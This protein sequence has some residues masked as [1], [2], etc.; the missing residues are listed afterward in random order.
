MR[1]A[2]LIL[3]GRSRC[4]LCEDMLAALEALRGEIP[5]EVEVVDIDADPLL[6][7]K[8]DERVPVLASG[9][10]ELCQYFLNLDAVRDFLWQ[11]R[12]TDASSS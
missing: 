12:R 8:Y 9:G 2:R 6:V 7:R 3:Y 4:H 1:P 11:W 10:S 5:F